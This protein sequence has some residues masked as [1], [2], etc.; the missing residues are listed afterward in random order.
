MT[1]TRLLFARHGRSQAAEE[2]R[3]QGQ[4]LAIP[5]TN[6]GKEQARIL[7]KNL[8][9]MSFDK[10]FTSTALRAIE[11]AQSI[12]E[13]HGKVPYLEIQEL[14]E[15]SKGIAEGMQNEE[16]SQKY[17]EIIQQWEEEIDARPVG[18]ENFEDVH[19]RVIP[20]LETHVKEYPGSVLLYVIHGNVIRVLLGHMLHVPFG[21]RARIKQDY[22]ALNSVV[23][24]HERNRW[25]IEYVNRVFH[26]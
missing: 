13:A 20:V 8:R 21:K 11:T 6:E 10:I 17:P 14:N 19:N 5:L 16:F 23:F 1:K 3:V 12:R 26:S 2:G 4:G 7:A 15:R 24:D 22:C 18:G 25:E 9:Q